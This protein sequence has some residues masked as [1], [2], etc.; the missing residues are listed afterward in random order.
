MTD[1]QVEKML[2]QGFEFAEQDLKARQLIDTRVEAE[3]IL[4]ASAKILKSAL[5]SS[6]A[7]L[8]DSISEEQ[9]QKIKTEMETVRILMAGNDYI[10]IKNALEKLEVLAKPIAETAM[11]R[12][13]QTSLKEKRV[14]D[15][16][17]KG[18]Q[19]GPKVE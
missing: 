13:L 11:N 9:I 19:N 12:A 8:P 16:L 1:E 18:I 17:E 14:E 7:A 15:V 3:G 6:T 10:A 5:S 2:E 4:Q